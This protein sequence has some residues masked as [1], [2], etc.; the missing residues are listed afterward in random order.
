M[1]TVKHEKEKILEWYCDV[2]IPLGLKCCS[3]RHSPDYQA[4]NNYFEL[5]KQ[6][7]SLID[8]A[9]NEKQPREETSDILANIDVLD[10]FGI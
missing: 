4:C 3:L 5:S 2:T 1:K 9:R 8:A 10:K 7:D 6:L